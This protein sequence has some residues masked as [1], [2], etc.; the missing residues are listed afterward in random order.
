M[1]DL[2]VT[3]VGNVTFYTL[4]RPFGAKSTE[5]NEA[6]MVTNGKL[7]LRI[8]VSK[9][10]GAELLKA[11][12]GNKSIKQIVTDSGEVVVRINGNTRFKPKIYDV[13]GVE[14]DAPQVYQGDKLKA[15]MA[16]KAKTYE[17]NGETGTSFQLMSVKIFEHDTS[18]RVQKEV[19]NSTSADLF[20]S[21]SAAEAELKSAKA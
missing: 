9:E 10:E 4:D 1:T 14:I 5:L 12:K 15:S 8:E 3:P 20:A 18:G 11:N 17:H 19:N 2:I 13:N 21:I 16:V 6:G 7:G